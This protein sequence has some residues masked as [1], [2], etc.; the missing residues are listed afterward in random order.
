M[1]WG[2]HS[3][4]PPWS[5]NGRQKGWTQAGLG[6]GHRDPGTFAI[7]ESTYEMYSPKS[8]L[9][10]SYITET[11]GKTENSLDVSSVTFCW[12]CKSNRLAAK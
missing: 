4:A 1:P 8:N 11:Y 12:P 5:S 3:L 2:L 9:P 10:C 6:A 7:P